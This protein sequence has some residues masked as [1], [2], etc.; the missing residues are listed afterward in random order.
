MKPDWDRLAN[1]FEGS[2]S[3]L[4][5]DVDC[6]VSA[7]GVPVPKQCDGVGSYPTLK[8]FRGSDDTTGQEYPETNAR[9]FRLLNQFARGLL[10]IRERFPLWQQI[11]ASVI[12]CGGTYIAGMVMRLW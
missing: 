10:P 6:T 1:R 2:S 7:K 11:L 5:A 9:S 8:V 12:I 3:L 4:I